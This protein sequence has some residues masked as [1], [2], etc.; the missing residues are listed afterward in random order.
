MTLREIRKARR[1]PRTYVEYMTGIKPNTLSKKESGLRSWT[2]DEFSALCDLYKVD[3]P[4]TLD[5][6]ARMK[7]SVTK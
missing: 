7:E 2:I 1:I 6:Y 5:D 3:E 4:T